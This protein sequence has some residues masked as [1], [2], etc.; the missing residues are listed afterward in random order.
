[1]PRQSSLASNRADKVC[2]TCGETFRPKRL[3]SR[4]CSKPCLWAKNGG[5]NR[6]EGPAWWK[7]LRRGYVVGRVWRNGKRVFCSQ[8][9]W[10]M[11]QHLGRD[12]SATEDVH[13]KN[14]IKTDN[15]I[16]N[17]ELIEHGKHSV[18]SNKTRTYRRG[19]KLKLTQEQRSERAERM[20][21][22]RAAQ[23]D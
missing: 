20:R 10:V 3:T 15:R 16:E 8:H 5:R 19:Y 1:M 22:M 11:E 21:R 23:K 17:L 6:K 13:H 12:L 4:F 18:L 14:G 7:H 9:R 2:E